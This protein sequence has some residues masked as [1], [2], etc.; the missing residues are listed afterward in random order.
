MVPKWSFPVRKQVRHDLETITVLIPGVTWFNAI[1]RR[2][3]R[4][5]PV[6]PEP[7]YQKYS[8]ILQISEDIF[9][10]MSFHWCR[11]TPY[12]SIDAHWHPKT[13]LFDSG[14]HIRDD[15]KSYISHHQNPRIQANRRVPPEP[16]SQCFTVGPQASEN[17]IGFTILRWC[18]LT[19]SG[20]GDMRWCP[21]TPLR[22]AKNQIQNWYILFLQQP[23]KLRRDWN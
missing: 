22:G 6:S 20:F 12:G 11:F 3:K 9:R 23:L 19:P 21:K 5:H 13:P 4:I 2:H 14:D 16:I 18:H 7:K 10:F 17:V 1:V 15:T 8:I